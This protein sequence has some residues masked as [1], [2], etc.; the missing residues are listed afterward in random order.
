MRHVE[1]G[2]GLPG[3]AEVEFGLVRS[4]AVGNGK[5]RLSSVCLYWFRYSSGISEPFYFSI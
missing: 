4:G 2:S 3:I 5:E 1:F